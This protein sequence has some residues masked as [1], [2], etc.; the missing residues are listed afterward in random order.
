MSDVSPQLVL[1][2]RIL[3]MQ[4]RLR[5]RLIPEMQ[6]WFI[7]EFA[8]LGANVGLM[9]GMIS[10]QCARYDY[11]FQS[12][13]SGMD[14]KEASHYA[15]MMLEE[16]AFMEMLPQLQWRSQYLMIYAAFEHAL[17]QLRT[18]A[19]CRLGLPKEAVKGSYSALERTKECM[20][21]CNVLVDW[22]GKDWAR[23]AAHCKLRNKITHANG[24]FVLADFNRSSVGTLP[25]ISVKVNNDEV[26]VNLGSEALLDAIDTMHRFLMLLANYE[27]PE[28]GR[29]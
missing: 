22:A 17:R 28:L 15:D 7:E 27:H 11:A 9:G 20:K 6:R 12:A 5:S 18:I 13:I 29:T 23:I 24:V 10:D 25:G 21:E 14:S 16:A 26:I 1:P 4:R 19:R 8:M 3:D 2:R